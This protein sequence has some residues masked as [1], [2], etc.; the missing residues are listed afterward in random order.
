MPEPRSLKGARILLVEDEYFVALELKMILGALGAEIVGP[1]SRLQTARELAKAERLDGAVLDVKLDGET[2]F[3]LAEELLDR[4][5]P[6]LF[7]TGFSRSVLPDRFK[8]APCLPKPVNG[9]AL[10]RLALTSFS[11]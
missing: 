2:T 11:R 3:P 7:T 5:V 10:R 4:G 1:A 9:A 8:G 6:V